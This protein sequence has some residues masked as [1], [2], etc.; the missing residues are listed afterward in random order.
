M[1][2]A[3]LSHP[4]KMMLATTL[5]AVTA[6]ANIVLPEVADPWTR[7]E[8]LTLKLALV[9][10]V[11]ILWRVWQADRERFRLEIEAQRDRH[12]AKMETIVREN[13]ESNKAVVSTMNRQVDF[14]ETLTRQ[15]MQERIK[16]HPRES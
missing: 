9:L 3:A 16:P 4:L 11:A 10:A 8:D 13:T 5:A 15:V 6:L 2:L 7:L 14:F 1:L 12:D